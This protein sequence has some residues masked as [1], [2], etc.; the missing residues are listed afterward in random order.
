MTA[1]LVLVGVARALL[2]LEQRVVLKFDVRYFR[3][4][5]NDLMMMCGNAE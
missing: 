2:S 3:I 4:W 5:S 1:P